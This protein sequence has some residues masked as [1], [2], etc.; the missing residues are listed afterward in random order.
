MAYESRDGDAALKWYGPGKDPGTI[1]PD[2]QDQNDNDAKVGALNAPTDL[3]KDAEYQKY[4]ESK[5]LLN[6]QSISLTTPAEATADINASWMEQFGTNAPKTIASAYYKELSRLQSGRVSGAV[7]KDGKTTINTQGVSGSEIKAIQNK[8]LSAAAS[9]LIT[10]ASKGDVKATAALQKGNFGLTYT[11]LKNAYAENGLPINV[12]AL[13][14][15]AVDSSVNP[16]LLKSNLNLI[17]LQAKTYFPALAD[18]IDKGYTVKQLLSPYLQTRANILEEDADGIDLKELQS[19]AKDPKGLVGL[20]DYEISLRKSPK[21]AYTK[22]AQD[23]LAGLA[24]D[25]TKMFGLG[26]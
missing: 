25:M 14:K 4:L 12:Q 22:N 5:A 13:G 1:A 17:N 11:T 24:R 20:Y 18:K 19:I 6:R 15:L 9:D 3:S 16:T 7:S 23:S 8:Y 26:A 2:Q 21:W 10:A